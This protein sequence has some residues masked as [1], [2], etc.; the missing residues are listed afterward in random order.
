MDHILGQSQQQWWMA[1]SP[2]HIFLTLKTLT[3]LCCFFPNT[4]DWQHR[5]SK[6]REL[7]VGSRGAPPNGWKIGIPCWRGASNE[8]DHLNAPKLSDF[9]HQKWST[10]VQNVPWIKAF[11]LLMFKNPFES[12]PCH[13][14]LTNSNVRS[15]KTS[16]GDLEI[17]WNLK[18]CCI[19]N[20]TMTSW[21]TPARTDA[22]KPTVQ[23]LLR[24]C[25][26]PRNQGGRAHGGLP[27]KKI[28]LWVWRWRAQRE[29]PVKATNCQAAVAL[30]A[31]L[32]VKWE[33]G[34]CLLPPSFL[35][36]N[37]F[38]IHWILLKSLK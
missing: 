29:I 25:M 31:R 36:E 22:R 30:W 27:S 16:R 26:V 1:L 34:I 6:R 7:S 14:T 11:H 35:G 3:G 38:L 17:L 10:F 33:I 37:H 9:V 20:I 15:C 12:F 18:L 2:I 5:R 19:V 23:F 13:M 4:W 24:R 8:S 28:H 32:S 21:L